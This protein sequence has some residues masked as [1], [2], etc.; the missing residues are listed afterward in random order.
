MQG[1]PR[2]WLEDEIGNVAVTAGGELVTRLR[3]LQQQPRL[4]VLASCQ[5]AGTGEAAH[6][7]D[8]GALAA[9][10]PRLAETGIPAVVAMQGN[11]SMQTVSRFM[12]LFFRELQKDGQIDRAVAVARSAVRNSYDYWMP[13][14]F[15]RLRS[16]RIWYTPGLDAGPPGFDKWDALLNHISRGRCTPILGYG[17]IEPLLGSSREIA[18]RWAETYRFPLAPDDRDDLPQVAQYLSVQQ[19]KAFLRDELNSYLRNELLRRYGPDLTGDATGATLD[20]LLLKVGARQREINRIEPHK[21]LAHLPCSIYITTKPDTLLS[22]ALTD[23]GREPKVEVCRWNEKIELSPSIYDDDPTY[24]PDLKQP[25]VYHLF[26]KLDQDDSLV[27]T[28]D[29]YFDYLIGVTTNKQLIPPPVRRA[30]TDTAL[31]F[32]G[33]QMD[34][35]NFRVLF[36]S[37]MSQEGRARR[38]DYTHVAVQIDPQGSHILEPE[39]ARRYLERY[40]GKADISIFWGSLEEFIKELRTRWINKYNTDFLPS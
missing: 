13:V 5:S 4:V 35:W 20:Q 2:L 10:G 19:D 9:L 38:D 14:L 8:D 34:D 6:S 7:T 17:L 28:E 3:E 27:L 25:L 37:L 40:F 24:R 23:A 39:L 11:V 26:G 31:L 15:M 33:F 21:V 36:R 1:Q 16:G 29:N 12:P 32:L 18:Q 22:E 30:L